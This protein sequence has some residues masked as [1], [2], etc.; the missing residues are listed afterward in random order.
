MSQAEH[1]FTSLKT[2]HFSFSMNCLK[3]SSVKVKI[4]GSSLAVQWLGF[5]PLTAMA[6]VQSLDGKRSSHNLRGMV[7]IK[8]KK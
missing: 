8:I 7:K 5:S 6:W 1:L 2:I 4:T 3:L